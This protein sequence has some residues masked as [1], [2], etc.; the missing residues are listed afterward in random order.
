LPMPGAKGNLSPERAQAVA[1][2]ASANE[3]CWEAREGP[4]N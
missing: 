1:D 2:S 4:R 3:A